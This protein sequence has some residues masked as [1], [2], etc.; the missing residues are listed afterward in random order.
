MIVGTNCLVPLPGY[1]VLPS[2]PYTTQ[3]P[4]TFVKKKKKKQENK[5][6]G[7]VIRRKPSGSTL[8]L[9]LTGSGQDQLVKVGREVKGHELNS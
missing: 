7:R 9:P 1:P 5:V 4:G 2:L 8:R 3:V 6:T